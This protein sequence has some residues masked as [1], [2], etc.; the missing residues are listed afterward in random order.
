MRAVP[1]GGSRKPAPGTLWVERK[2]VYAV[3]AKRSG[4][5]APNDEGLQEVLLD[6]AR[7]NAGESLQDK[8]FDKATR[9]DARAMAIFQRMLR[10]QLDQAASAQ[11]RASAQ[12]T[13][14]APRRP[15]Y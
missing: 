3:C 11:P 8:G 14:K 6:E 12:Q 1:A 7:S 15:P 13:A 9:D 10:E 5:A 2:Q 4:Y